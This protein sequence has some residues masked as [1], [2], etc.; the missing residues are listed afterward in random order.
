MKRDSKWKPGLALIIALSMLVFGHDCVAQTNAITYQGRLSDNGVAANG[1]Y[2]LSFQVFGAPV[3]GSQVGPTLTNANLVVSDGV[4]TATLNFGFNVFLGADRWLQI[5]VRSNGN[6]GA[7]IPLSPRQLFTP[8]P[9]ALYTPTA[10]TAGGVAGNSIT[11]DG[12]Q[13]DTITGDKI[14]GGQVV[15]SL[16]GLYDSVFLSAGANVTVTQN[17]NSLEISALNLEGWR[18]SGNTGTTPSQNFIGTTDNQPLDLRVNNQRALRLQPSA[19]GPNLLGGYIGNAVAAGVYGATIAGGGGPGAGNTILDNFATISGGAGN[20]IEAANGYSIIGGGGFNVVQTN[21]YHST[22]GG[23]HSNTIMTNANQSTIAGGFN[24]TIRQDASQAAIG[25]GGFNSASGAQSVVAGGSQNLARGD[26]SAVAGGLL[27]Y[28]AGDVC[29][30]GGGYS[31]SAWGLY[32]TLAGG[33]LNNAVDSF[34]FVGGGR[35][36][37]ASGFATTIGGGEANSAIPSH[38]SIAGGYSN[39][40]LSSATYAVIGGGYKNNIG[41]NAFQTTIAGG[42]VNTIE[43]DAWTS[44]IS[45]GHGNRIQNKAL[46]ATIGGGDHNLIGTNAFQAIIAG[47]QSNVISYLCSDGVIGGGWGNAILTSASQSTIAGGAFNAIQADCFGCTIGGG[48]INTN[49]TGAS[50][51][52]ISGGLNN[53]IGTNSACAMIP[54]GT[55]NVAA[56]N[57]S[58]AAGRRAKA[59]HAGAF[60]W[61]DS[62]DTDIASSA[63]NQFTVRASGGVRLFSNNG[64]AG[65]SLAAGDTSWGV[66]S[67]RDAKKHI[68]QVDGEEVLEKLAAVPVSKWNYKWEPDNAT[69]HIGPMAQAFKA[70]FYP[71]RDDKSITTLEFD[72]VALAAIQG[73]NQKLIETVKAKDA[74]IAELEKRLEKIESLVLRQDTDAR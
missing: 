33:Y 52:V 25:G 50:Y 26:Y 20:S 8:T 45:G 41:I 66:I 30:I 18:L 63:V 74:R 4:F 43:E 2:D 53:A 5:G 21:A 12:I 42:V 24:N 71:G 16:N 70:A 22:I 54:G 61:A 29:S 17:G 39:S 57:F 14:A 13:N 69:P 31:N 37:S 72:G 48:R 73:L 11:G 51:G 32:A 60:V 10:G 3:G 36:N 49:R 19:N 68:A 34:S 65:V 64:T 67:D 1:I 23:G 7:Y 9:Y 40:I 28:T 38:S 55:E 27:N 59:N 35:E 15:K 58:F 62:T 47:G 44:T 46:A 6:V 56:G